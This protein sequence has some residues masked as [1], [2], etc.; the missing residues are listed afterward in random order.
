[1]PSLSEVATRCGEERS[2]RN[3]F[4]A[5]GRPGRAGMAASGR[6]RG[7]CPSG[8]TLD[9]SPSFQLSR[10]SSTSLRPPQFPDADSSGALLP[11]PDSWATAGLTESRP[12]ARPDPSRIPEQPVFQKLFSPSHLG[13]WKRGRSVPGRRKKHGRCAR[14]RGHVRG[15]KREVCCRLRVKGLPDPLSIVLITASRWCRHQPRKE[16]P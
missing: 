2:R 3:A 14:A 6:Q 5:P 7:F 1:M 8:E 10:E 12:F 9:L 11:P 16:L 13:C 15:K 4:A